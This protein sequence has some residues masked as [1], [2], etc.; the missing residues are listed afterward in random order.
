MNFVVSSMT[1]ASKANVEAQGGYPASEARLLR[2]VERSSYKPW[3]T[4]EISKASQ[5][6]GGEALDQN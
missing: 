4:N 5:I 1:R 6:S 2:Y 3:G